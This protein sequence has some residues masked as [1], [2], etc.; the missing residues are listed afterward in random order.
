VLFTASPAAAQII[1]GPPG[2]TFPGK[3]VTVTASLGGVGLPPP[4]WWGPYGYG[5]PF[6]GTSISVTTVVVPRPV[7][8]VLAPERDDLDDRGPLLIVPGRRRLDDPPPPDGLMRPLRPGERPRARPPAEPPPA[9]APPAPPAPVKPERIPEL[10]L[11]PAPEPTP[12][13]EAAR[14]VRLGREAFAG[15]EYG[16]A[17]ERFARAAEVFPDEPL[18]GFLLAQAYFARGQ[19]AEAFAAL[20]AAFRSR[21]AGPGDGFVPRALYGER[22]ADFAA[23]LQAL[24]DALARFPDDPV[25]LF[26]TGYELWFNGQR[27]EARP[28]LKRALPLLPNPAAFE[29]FV[30]GLDGPVAK[31]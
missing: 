8:V 20:E 27:E 9:P 12:P 29:R 23:H 16:R 1:L 4:I 2:L 7:V 31:K 24:R 15:G 21:P 6:G 11:A 22:A 10:P 13:A 3:R 19:Y 26:L 30:Q 17:A 18:A 5:G 28:L 25:L 14:Q